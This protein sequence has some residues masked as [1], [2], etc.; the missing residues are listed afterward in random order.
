VARHSLRIKSLRVLGEGVDLSATYTGQYYAFDAIKAP[1]LEIG[2]FCTSAGPF[3]L[4]VLRM[5]W[6]VLLAYVDQYRIATLFGCTSFQGG[7]P[8][9]RRACTF[10]RRA[11]ADGV[12]HAH[13]Y[14]N[15]RTS[16]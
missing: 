11:I 7:W 6:A 1:A 16:A 5:A 10:P 13:P 4:D 2:R 3:S 12:W 8:R 15:S 9:K 14:S